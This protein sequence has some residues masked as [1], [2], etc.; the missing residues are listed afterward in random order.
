MVLSRPQLR[1]MVW[2]VRMR[3]I[4]RPKVEVEMR[5]W[6]RDAGA[7]R[8]VKTSESSEEVSESAGLGERGLDEEWAESAA[9]R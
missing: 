3:S 9:G 8:V 7:V 1:R 6:R 4:S 5:A 2:M